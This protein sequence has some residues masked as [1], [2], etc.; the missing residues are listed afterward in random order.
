[1]KDTTVQYIL[2][3]PFPTYENVKNIKIKIKNQFGLSFQT[4]YGENM[5]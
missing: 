5:K 4:T 2:E 3:N 1:M